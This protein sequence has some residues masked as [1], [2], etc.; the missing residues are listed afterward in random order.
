MTTDALPGIAQSRPAPWRS[1]VTIVLLAAMVGLGV[2]SSRPG[3]LPSPDDPQPVV[4]VFRA[5]VP[6][7]L[8]LALPLQTTDLVRAVVSLPV[9]LE[10]LLVEIDTDNTVRELRPL[11]RRQSGQMLEFSH[12][13]LRPMALPARAGT[14]LYLACAAPEK[15]ALAD[16]VAALPEGSWPDLPDYFLIRFTHRGL[17]LAG[18][19][20]PRL[21]DPS[22]TAQ[23]ELRLRHLLERLAGR[24]SFIVGVALPVRGS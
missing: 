23:A 15:P 7:D 18:P 2:L 14:K 20:G 16:V 24:C 22:V 1:V 13:P 21:P 12:P 19:R 6:L 8:L 17:E 4:Q 11:E 5:E 10:P 3:R 9:G